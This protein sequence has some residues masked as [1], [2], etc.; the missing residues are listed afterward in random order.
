MFHGSTFFR[1]SLDLC[2]I[3]TVVERIWNQSL[4]EGEKQNAWPMSQRS[5]KGFN[6]YILSSA[7]SF[8][9]GCARCDRYRTRNFLTLDPPRPCIAITRGDFLDINRFSWSVIVR[10]NLF[11]P[12]RDK[13]LAGSV[14]LRAVYAALIQSNAGSSLCRWWVHIATVNS[15]GFY[16]R[17]KGQRRAISLELR[18]LLARHLADPSIPFRQ[19]LIVHYRARI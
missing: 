13:R 7:N 2:I 11:L 3:S 12:K 10:S 16:L 15:R 8:D 5:H 1:S 19:R 4:S 6:V 14:D 17:G 9:A 18:R